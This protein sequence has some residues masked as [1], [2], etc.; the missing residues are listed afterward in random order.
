MSRD[1]RDRCRQGLINPCERSLETASS[2]DPGDAEEEHQ[3]QL[4]RCQVELV[5]STHS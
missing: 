3:S 2:P 5:G 1:V 4:S